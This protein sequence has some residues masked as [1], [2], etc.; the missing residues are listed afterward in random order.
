MKSPL[1]DAKLEILAIRMEGDSRERL[2]QQKLDCQVNLDNCKV[3]IVA[4]KKY[5]KVNQGRSGKFMIDEAGRIFGIKGYGKINLKKQYGTLDTVSDWFW[6]N[7]YPQ[8]KAV[9]A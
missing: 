1:F 7:Y 8:K 4:G 3:E 6:G 2:A 5:T 9:A